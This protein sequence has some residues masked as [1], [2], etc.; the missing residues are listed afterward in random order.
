VK[1]NQNVTIDETN[2]RPNLMLKY[3]W[4]VEKSHF[5]FPKNGDALRCPAFSI[6]LHE[7]RIVLSRKD[8][9]QLCRQ[10]HI[11]LEPVDRTIANQHLP[12][13]YRL[14]YRI[15]DVVRGKMLGTIIYFIAVYKIRIITHFFL[16]LISVL[17]IR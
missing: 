1:V 4:T 13:K 11:E 5:S 3:E 8:G 2:Q 17:Y 14:M 15:Y 7:Y 16:H 9:A 12:M 6:G 10:Y